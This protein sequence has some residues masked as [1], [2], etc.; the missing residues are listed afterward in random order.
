MDELVEDAELATETMR[1]LNPDAAPV[2]VPLPEWRALVREK[3][4]LE[5]QIAEEM[6]QISARVGKV[7]VVANPITDYDVLAMDEA[8]QLHAVAPQ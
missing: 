1:N 8:G 2:R 6:G 7:E 3:A 5:H 4:R